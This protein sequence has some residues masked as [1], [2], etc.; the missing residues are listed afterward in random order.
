[1]W[2]EDVPQW[3]EVCLACTRPW[4]SLP[5]TEGNAGRGKGKKG[6]GKGGGKGRIQR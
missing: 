5:N 4:S 2:V 3:R 6:G 1:M